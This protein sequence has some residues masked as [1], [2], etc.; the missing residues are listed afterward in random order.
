M[1]FFK[2]ISLDGKV[3]VVTG[4]GRG[5]GRGI[6]LLMA[7][8]GAKVVV[9]DLG[10]DSGSNGSSTM[11]ANDVVAE[12]KSKGGTAVPSYASVANAEGANSIIRTAMENFGKIDILVNN[13]GGGPTGP[14]IDAEEWAWDA[15]M[16]LNLKSVFLLS[17]RAARIMKDH[18]GGS[19]INIAS[20]WGMVPRPNNIYGVAKAGVIMLTK[21]MAKDWGQYNIRVNAIAPGGIKTPGSKFVWGDPVR[22]EEVAK[23][24]ALHRWGTPED[25]AAVALFLASEVSPHI[26]GVVLPVDGGELV[27]PP[28][29]P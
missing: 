19:I 26:T 24:I 25:I 20:V 12:I 2:K 4:A 10:T 14:I 23:A 13:A 29:F 3:A 17:Q 21:C 22:A 15:T 5:I 6:A 18:G 16:N 28:V 1:D 27:G 9:N 7:E 8:A 11:P